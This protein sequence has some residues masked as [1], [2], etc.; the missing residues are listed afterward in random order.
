MIAAM[1]N[2]HAATL[3]LTSTVNRGFISMPSDHAGAIVWGCVS[4]LT[5]T[6]LP[7]FMSASAPPSRSRPLMA[8]TQGLLR[9][10]E[11]YPCRGLK[12]RAWARALR[13]RFRSR[14]I[15]L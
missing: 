8:S 2:R 14:G 9:A 15:T 7:P 5:G 10:S 12:V 6:V 4:R 11:A 1:P 3:I 13:P